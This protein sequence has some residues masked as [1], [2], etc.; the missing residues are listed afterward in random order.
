MKLFLALI[1]GLV[2]WPTFLDAKPPKHKKL[3]TRRVITVK[4][5][6]LQSLTQK[7]NGKEDR[8]KALVD[9]ARMVQ[10]NKLQEQFDDEENDVTVELEQDGLIKYQNGQD[11]CMD[12]M[13]VKCSDH[14]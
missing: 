2:F 13:D 8:I 11:Q 14:G 9:G 10:Q 3:P 12:A 6:V 4:D 5:C 1:F 7:M